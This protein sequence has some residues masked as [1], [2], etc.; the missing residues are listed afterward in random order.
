MKNA[1]FTKTENYA[2]DIYKKIMNYH[3]NSNLN[4]TKN[5]SNNMIER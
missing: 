4:E 2:I 5:I 3:K 1:K